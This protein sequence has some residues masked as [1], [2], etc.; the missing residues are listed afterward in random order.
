VSE[1]HVYHAI[2]HNYTIKTPR[3]CTTFF[4]KTPIKTPIHHHRKIIR[5]QTD[6]TVAQTTKSRE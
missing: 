1:H 5:A 6:F 4:V 3:S 2:H